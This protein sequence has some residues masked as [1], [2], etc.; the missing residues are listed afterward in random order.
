VGQFLVVKGG[1][2]SVVKNSFFPKWDNLYTKVVIK[3]FKKSGFSRAE[4]KGQQKTIKPVLEKY[5]YKK[6]VVAIKCITRQI[7]TDWLTAALFE[8]L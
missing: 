6:S 4:A 1:P 7:N 8:T 5:G 3:K 2:F